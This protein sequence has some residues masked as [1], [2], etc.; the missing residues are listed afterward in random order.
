M[1]RLYQSRVLPLYYG[2]SFCVNCF[3]GESTALEHGHLAFDFGAV[4]ASTGLVA[5]VS[6]LSQIVVTQSDLAGPGAHGVSRF[7][8]SCHC[9]SFEVERD[10]GFEPTTYT[11]ATCRS[12]S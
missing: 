5:H 7:I 9:D 4:S 2:S 8:H 3:D 12:T 6:Q 1:A 10:I 11:L